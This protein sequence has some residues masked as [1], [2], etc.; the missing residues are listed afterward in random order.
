MKALITADLHFS[1]TSSIL[2]RVG[3]TYTTRLENCIQTQNWTER[4]A[5]ELGCDTIIHLGD[6]FDKP[7]LTDQEITACKEIQWSK[8]KHYF[9]VGNHESGEISLQFSSAKILESSTREIISEAVKL[10][11]GN[12]ELC[13]LPYISECERK[14]LTEYFGEKTDIPRIILS[15]NDIKGIQMGPIVSRLGFEKE[16]IE[17]SCDLFVNGHL[18]NG[19]LLSEVII[20]L[21]NITGRDFGEDATRYAHQA[22]ILDTNEFTFKYIEN[23]NAFNFYKLEIMNEEQLKI[24][25]TLKNNAVLSIKCL[26]KLISILREKIETLT[27]IFE[28]RVI[29]VKPTIENSDEITVETL[30]ANV[31][32]FARFVEFC[33]ANIE[34]S[35]I[36]EFELAEVCK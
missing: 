9:I 33:R 35:D 25:D 5:E 24:L 20:N 21:G 27:N 29:A 13:F 23:P 22:A 15:H 34:N 2:K 17:S 6:Y 7:N 28:Y 11:L 3:R 32:H 1:E 31:D 16:E 19:Q 12:C 18:H 30:S 10:D 14:T 26:D 8:I 4:L 36:L